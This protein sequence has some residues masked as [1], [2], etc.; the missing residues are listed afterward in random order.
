VRLTKVLWP[1]I[2]ICSAVAAL[3][4]MLVF[5]GIMVR[6][7]LIM[8]FLF[9]CPGMAVVRFLHLKEAIDKF[10]LATALSFSIDGLVAGIY[11][12]TNHW[13]P[14]D[15]LITLAITSIVAVIVELTNAHVFIYKHVGLVQRF[16]A[17]LSHPLIIG[18]RSATSL[19][20][21]DLVADA[22]TIRVISVQSIANLLADTASE[23][24]EAMATVQLAD[25]R[26]SPSARE[27]FEKQ[28]TVQMPSPRDRL[29]NQ[30]QVSADTQRRGQGLPVEGPRRNEAVANKN[31]E[32]KDTLHVASTPT[33]PQL[34]NEDADKA[35]SEPQWMQTQL[36]IKNGGFPADIEQSSTR[37]ITNVSSAE[38]PGEERSD[39]QRDTRDNARINAQQ[40]DKSVDEPDT[41]R[42]AKDNVRTSAQQPDNKE[43]EKSD[44]FV[45][46]QTPRKKRFATKITRIEQ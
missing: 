43:G 38:Q 19:Y 23:G 2:I 22:A 44:S 32:E 30:P 17:L 24:I 26:L 10:A 5:P 39:P 7:P 28:E 15:I 35:V 20:E 31:I 21:E 3:M 4:A 8:L 34:A 13:S 12:Y 14:A 40:P 41:Q 18:T 42:F 1:I 25:V 27:R 11:L 16:G 33:T 45:N 46:S 29:Q 37:H 36:N 6:P 9:I